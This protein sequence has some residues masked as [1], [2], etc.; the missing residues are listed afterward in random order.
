MAEPSSLA[1]LTSFVQVLLDDCVIIKCDTGLYICQGPPGEGM[2]GISNIPG[3]PGFL[4][5]RGDIA[6]HIRAMTTPDDET[7]E[8]SEHPSDDDGPSSTN[9]DSGATSSTGSSTDE[10]TIASHVVVNVHGCRKKRRRR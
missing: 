4:V 8:T 6:A 5:S 3:L 10:D 1:D 7:S 2:E 9:S